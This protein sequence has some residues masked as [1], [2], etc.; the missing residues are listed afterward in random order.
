MTE[1]IAA[2]KPSGDIVARVD[3]QYRWRTWAL[4]IFLLG[5]GLYSLHDGF[6]AYPRDN[7]AWEQMGNRVDRPLRPPHDPPGIV[8]NQ[9]A[10][11]LCTALSIPILIWRERRSRGE[12]RLSGN[13]LHVPGQA[14]IEMQEIQGLD[15]VRWDRKGI[16]VIECQ[17]PGGMRRVAINDMIYQ[18]QPT[19]Q[20]VDRIEAHLTAMDASSVQPEAGG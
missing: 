13:T 2:P 1:P 14:P 18:R 5:I 9:F 6:I 4:G 12:Y 15:L 20:I 17:S 10:G 7:A 19:D 16:A 11:V 3:F 8:F